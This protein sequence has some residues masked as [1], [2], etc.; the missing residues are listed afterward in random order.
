MVTV[1][2]ETIAPRVQMEV[3]EGETHPRTMKTR[4]LRNKRRE[5]LLDKPERFGVMDIMQI[6]EKA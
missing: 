1:R 4:R 5:G 3:S 6:K 2:E